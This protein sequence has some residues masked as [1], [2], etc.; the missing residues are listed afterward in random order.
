VDAGTDGKQGCGDQRAKCFTSR[1]RG[2]LGLWFPSC[3][4]THI[5]KK[6]IKLTVPGFEVGGNKPN[7][8]AITN[9]LRN[10]FETLYL[11]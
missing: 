4:S 2:L 7:S 5:R 3:H 1:T 6:K 8:T 11:K 10:P 9:N